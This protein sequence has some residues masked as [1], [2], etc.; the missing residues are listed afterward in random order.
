MTHR[1]ESAESAITEC[2]A[3]HVPLPPEELTAL[4]QSPPSPEMGDYGLPCFK[5]ARHLRMA[6]DRIAQD[7][8]GKLD[9]PPAVAEVRAE[10][11]YLNFFLDRPG[12]LAAGLATLQR[13]PEPRAAPSSARS[14]TRA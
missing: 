9:L 11:A 13:E 6:P 2:L 14:P 4:L 7:L 1:V 8:Q 5:L 12:F 10:G 3:P